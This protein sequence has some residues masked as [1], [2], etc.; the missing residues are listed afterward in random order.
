MALQ[1]TKLAPHFAALVGPIDLRATHAP[2]ALAE[3]RAG[4]DEYAVLV[5]RDQPFTDAEQLDFAQRLDGE[6]HTRTG[7]R[8]L[9]KSR[10]GNEAVADI[11]N[12]DEGGEIIK[13]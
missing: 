12:V 4:M 13:S 8:A 6:L 2:E 5:F 3:I 7:S 9:Y 1:F 11:S 10:L